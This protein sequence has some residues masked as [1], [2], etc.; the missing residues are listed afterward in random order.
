MHYIISTQLPLQ[1][2]QS[3]RAAEYTGY[4]SAEG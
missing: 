4:I 2:A 3:A 1:M